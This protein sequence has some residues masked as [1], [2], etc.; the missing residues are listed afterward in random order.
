MQQKNTTGLKL[1]THPETSLTFHPFLG[2]CHWLQTHMHTHTPKHI[3][4][5]MFGHTYAF[6][7][8]NIF[9]IGM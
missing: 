1:I 5:Q 8:I 9:S 4:N 6:F 7:I 3:T 2:I